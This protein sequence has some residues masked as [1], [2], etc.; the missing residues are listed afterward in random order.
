MRKILRYLART[1][2]YAVIFTAVMLLAYRL[3]DG[4][5]DIPSLLVCG[6]F[7]KIVYDCVFELIRKNKK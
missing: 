5:A 2:A 7:G 6:F 1:F 3:A 4:D